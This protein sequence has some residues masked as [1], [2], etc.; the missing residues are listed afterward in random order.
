MLCAVV[1]GAFG[2]LPLAVRLAAE[3]LDDGHEV[4]GELVLVASHLVVENQEFD[5]VLLKDPGKEFEG[6]AAESVLVGNHDLL[7]M[8]LECEFQNGLK[9]LAFE[10]DA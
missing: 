7:E 6:E 8:S 3:D 10:V 5:S 2:V 9:P 4:L 1:S